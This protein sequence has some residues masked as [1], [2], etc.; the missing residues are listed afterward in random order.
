[1]RLDVVGIVFVDFS[2]KDKSSTSLTNNNYA[3]NNFMCISWNA[4]QHVVPNRAHALQRVRTVW[5]AF[6][7]NFVLERRCN[8]V[9]DFEVGG[10][11]LNGS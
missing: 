1:M 4:F 6:V 9:P 10:H 7:P 5:H 8:D 11:T 2:R 3:H